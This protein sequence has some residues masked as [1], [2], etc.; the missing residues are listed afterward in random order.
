MFSKAKSTSLFLSV[1][2][3]GLVTALCASAC[4]GMG[5]HK[6]T[7]EGTKAESSSC[8]GGAA[9]GHSSKAHEHKKETIKSF[10]PKGPELQETPETSSLCPLK[11]CGRWTVQALFPWNMSF[12]TSVDV[13]SALDF[14]ISVAG[15]PLLLVVGHPEPSSLPLYLERG[16][17][18]L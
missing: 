9:K 6:K 2:T 16:V 17:L 18:R 14:G 1:L 7:T 4:D 13:F 12:V 15:K 3:S 11:D 8:H 5:A 10:T